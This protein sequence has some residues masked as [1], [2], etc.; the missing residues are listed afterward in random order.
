MRHGRPN[1]RLRSADGSAF[2][3]SAGR[4]YSWAR[5]AVCGLPRLNARV[6]TPAATGNDKD[7]D[8]SGCRVQPSGGQREGAR[9]GKNAGAARGGAKTG[10]YA[11]FKSLGSGEAGDETKGLL[12]LADAGIV[13]KSVLIWVT[14]VHLLQVPVH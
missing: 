8:R 4:G 6:D 11:V 12:C 2:G 13:R 3:E 14:H 5:D 10:L 9:P 7:N 1:Q